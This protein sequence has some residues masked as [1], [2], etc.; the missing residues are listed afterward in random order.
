M[1]G[2]AVMDCMITGFVIGR[3]W[4]RVITVL[5]FGLVIGGVMSWIEWVTILYLEEDGV[6]AALRLCRKFVEVWPFL[7]MRSNVNMRY[8][9]KYTI[10]SQWFHAGV[11]N[12]ALESSTESIQSSW[13]AINHPSYPDKCIWFPHNHSHVAGHDAP[14]NIQEK[15][16][17]PLENGYLCLSI[18]ISSQAPRT[19]IKVFLNI[20]PDKLH[21]I[22]RENSHSNL[23][24]LSFIA[25]N[26]IKGFIFRNL[27][28]E[29]ETLVIMAPWLQKLVR[30][31]SRSSNSSG[32]SVADAPNSGN[33]GAATTATATNRVHTTNTTPPVKNTFL[34][35]DPSRTTKWLTMSRHFNWETEFCGPQRMNLTLFPA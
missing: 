26:R 33:S 6:K 13:K 32:G 1:D 24:G 30:A 18:R 35:K 34:L 25:V 28:I 7:Q 21:T 9:P 4:E 10:L 2:M 16:G 29:R 14:A 17:R 8:Q 11:C 3:V 23:T 12:Q 20:H 31:R 22:R 19:Q 5:N 27:V 15:S